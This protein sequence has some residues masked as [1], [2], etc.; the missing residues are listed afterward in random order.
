MGAP[1]RHPR[2]PALSPA[3]MLPRDMLSAQ[4]PDSKV[5]GLASRLTASWMQARV[6]KAARASARFS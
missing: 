3:A 2:W 5:Y 4:K 6:M 1:E